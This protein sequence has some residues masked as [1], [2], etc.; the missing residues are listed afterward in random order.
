MSPGSYELLFEGSH[1]IVNCD[2]LIGVVCTGGI[3]PLRFRVHSGVDLVI[4]SM[5]LLLVFLLWVV[6]GVVLAPLVHLGILVDVRARSGCDV[7]LWECVVIGVVRKVNVSVLTAD[8]K[9]ALGFDLLG[10]VITFTI[11]LSVTEN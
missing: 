6:A 3:P 4:I 10:W 7:T 2:I 1:Q 8:V 5:G 9:V 11:S